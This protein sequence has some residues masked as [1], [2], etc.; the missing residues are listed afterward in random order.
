MTDTATATLD[1]GVWAIGGPLTYGTVRKV[2][3]HIQNAAPSTS[4]VVLDLAN[5]THC[6]SAAL[7]FLIACRRGT[8]SRPSQIDIRHAPDQ[9]VALASAHGVAALFTTE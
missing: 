6:D 9:L 3:D 4:I 2:F 8:D 7:A 1:E 5:V